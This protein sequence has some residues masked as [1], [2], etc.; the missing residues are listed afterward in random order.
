MCLFGDPRAQSHDRLGAIEGGIC[1]SSSTL[2][3]TVPA[4]GSRY[5]P[6]H[7]IVKGST[8]G[9]TRRRSRA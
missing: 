5:R 3:T 9:N 4:G 1:D 7:L 2:T 6:N 8:T